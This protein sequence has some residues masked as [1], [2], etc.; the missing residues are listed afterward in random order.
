MRMIV[1]SKAHV[2]GLPLKLS[3]STFSWNVYC[4]MK[5]GF[6]IFTAVTMKNTVFWDVV[7]CRCCANRRFGG[8][9]GHTRSTW[10]HIPEEGILRPLYNLMQCL[11]KPE[12][13]KIIIHEYVTEKL[14]F[15]VF[16]KIFAW[17]FVFKINV[18]GG[19]SWFLFWRIGHA[20]VNLKWIATKTGCW[21]TFN[22]E[23]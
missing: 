4:R 11:F 13:L 10:R 6:Y 20:W 19:S 16:L 9:S 5:N 18:F 22:M 3:H 12:C 17:M 15:L 14:I 21:R 2:R 1:K 8:T 7:P 23:D